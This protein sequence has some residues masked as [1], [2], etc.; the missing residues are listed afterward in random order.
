MTIDRAL[1]K[2]SSLLAEPFCLAFDLLRFRMVQTL[3][4][5]EFDNLPSRVAEVA[6]RS[7]VGMGA[8]LFG[9]LAVRFPKVVLGSTLG[10]ALASRITRIGGF[11]LQKGGF[12]PVKLAG[13][14]KEWTGE[15]KALSW[16]ICAPGGGM[17][18]DHG[19]VIPWRGR[20]DRIVEKIEEEDP[21]VL[22]LCEAVYDNACAE[23]LLDRLGGR[24]AHAVTLAGPSP[25]G[26][27]GGYMLFS[28]F[29]FK[30]VE[31]HSFS[32][33]SV[34]LNRGF[35]A[36]ELKGADG[37]A[38]CRLVGTHLI[39]E[40]TE[41]AKAKRAV[42]VREIRGYLETQTRLP[43]LLMG[44][45]NMRVEEEGGLL[46]PFLERGYDQSNPT[47]TNMLVEKWTKE[48]HEPDEVI[49]YMDRWEE[50]GGTL[51]DVRLVEAFDTSYNTKNALSDHHVLVGLLVAN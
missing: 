27:V 23:A 36:V 49:D 4:P 38:A 47:R 46:D 34:W 45:L 42:Q 10:L 29:P 20:I 13:E 12:T 51:Q 35:L 14:E 22:F 7:F 50:G 40:N 1:L 44:D 25:W 37:E 16:N 48:P 2:A 8:L 24:Y 6:F 9:Y 41:Q 31:H 17:T 19:G 3:D 43:T 28:K 5:K 30:K 21:D 11:A 39:H 33:N 26:S 32:N 18:R 15:V